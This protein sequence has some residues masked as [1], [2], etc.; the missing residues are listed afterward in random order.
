MRTYF[1]FIRQ[2]II[3]KNTNVNTAILFL[4]ILS[5]FLFLNPDL[6]G[7][8]IN[9][10]VLD[11][12]TLN[13]AP[14][15]TLEIK[16]KGIGWV[17]DSMGSFTLEIPKDKIS[18]NDT[19]LIRSLG[20]NSSEVLVKNILNKTS[21]EFKLKP[22]IFQL[23]SIIVKPKNNSFI[24]GVTLEKMQVN[25]RIKDYSQITVYMDNDEGLKAI[26]QNVSF[27]ISREGKPKAPFRIRFYEVQEDGSP[28]R[29]LTKESIIVTP[30]KGNA[31]FKIDVSKYKILV[32]KEG[33][34]VAME[35]IFTEKK[36]YFDTLIQGK[37]WRSYGQILGKIFN[38]KTV[39]HSW[40]YTLGNGWLKQ[41]KPSKFQS[42]TAFYNA[43][44]NSE[45][46]PIE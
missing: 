15:S 19:L 16:G 8:T 1:L 32:P 41:D 31:W 28:G 42:K 13:T 30:K 20:F 7:Q 11:T 14:Y 25:Y 24:K 43:M 23:D 35:W 18:E 44:I 40:I 4:R 29:D 9:G 33:Y 21:I 5:F 46:K 10:R 3:A 27:F 2:S 6:L 38:E 36:Y 26:I 17:S 22:S 34:F 37:N 39:P 12:N 45:I